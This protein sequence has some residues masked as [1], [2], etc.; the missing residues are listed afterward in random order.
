MKRLLNALC[1][2][3]AGLLALPVAAQSGYPAKPVE[4]V[5]GFP[6]GGGNDVLTRIVADK[7]QAA[8]RQPFVVVNRPGADG[9]IAF[10][11]VK[12]AAPDGY[13]LL[14]GPS[15]GMTVNPA[16]Y[17]KL[18]YD[19]LA[20]FE[21]ISMVGG[22]PLFV[23]VPPDSPLRT[24]GELVAQAKQKPGDLAY[25]SAATSFRMATEMFAQRAGISL[26][27]VPYQGSGKAV[28]AVMARE[29]PLSFA[30]AAAATAQI[31]GGRLRALAVSTAQRV[32][33]LPEVPTIAETG[34]PGFD[35]VL[36]SGLFAPRGTPPDIVRKLQAEVAKIVRQP[37][38]AARLEGMGVVPIGGSA[39]EL[40]GAMS[41][42]IGQ[43]REVARRAGIK[44]E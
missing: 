30:D 44:V 22:F 13:T 37:D 15:S 8:L 21:P 34:Y 17:A 33:G 2:C 36:W 6:P 5:V 25:G 4:I 12:R 42:Q 41:S 43:Y 19:P 31:K 1:L 14:V 7:L 27:H 23:V 10:D 35:V 20:D 39:E 24:L 28:Q 29:V 26:F 32:P 9:I 18:P 16:V 11:T 3:C 40:R 38:V